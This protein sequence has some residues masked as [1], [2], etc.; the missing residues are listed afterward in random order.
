MFSYARYGE[1]VVKVGLNLQPGQ[2]LLIIGPLTSGGV[3]LD[4][5]PL[6]RHVTESAYRAGARLVEAIWGDEALQLARFRN[7][8]RDSFSEFS[9]WLPPALLDHVQ[10][11]DAVLSIYANDP[12]FL[13]GQPPPLV[14]AVQQAAAVNVRGFR[15][16]ISGNRT[17][18]SVVAAPNAQWAARV[19]PEVGES[20]RITRLAE[21]IGQLCRLDD[22]DPVHAWET[23]LAG[24]AERRDRLNAKQYTALKYSAPGTD[25]T[26]G[27]PRGHLWVGGR[28]VSGDGIPFTAN[29]PTEEVFTMPH[30]ERVEG[31]VRS[32]KPL[33]YGGSL[34]ED[35]TVRFAAGRVVAITAARGEEILRELVA[36]DEGAA[37]LGEIA[38]VPHGSLVSRSGRLFFNTLF[39]ENAASHVALGSA[40]RFTLTGGEI[41]D[42]ETFCAAGGNR[43]AIHIDFMM[44]S[45]ALDVAGILESGASE[46]IMRRGEWSV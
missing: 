25:L 11:G 32:T 8:P 2:R 17:N 3:N 29:L 41:L 31:V 43:S 27:L 5:A 10:H 6:V 16:L 1:L 46:P 12:D 44:G 23:H 30:R 4:A 22:E 19:F 14:S 37:R 33:S 34:I 15:N 40:Y 39:D 28:S 42:D 13:S 36:T 20:D 7:A 21:T 18:W 26:I 38:L 35:F 24:L 45:D 9:R